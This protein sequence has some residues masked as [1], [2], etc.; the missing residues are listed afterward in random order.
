MPLAR[1]APGDLE[2]CFNLDGSDVRPNKVSMYFWSMTD[3]PELNRV[4]DSTQ[5]NASR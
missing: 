1:P 2:R 3:P 4:L 5:L